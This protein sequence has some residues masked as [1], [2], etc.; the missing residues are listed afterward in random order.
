MIANRVRGLLI[1][2]AFFSLLALGWFASP[3]RAIDV[4]LDEKP[5]TLKTQPIVVSDQVMVPIIEVK[6]PW[7]ARSIWDADKSSLIVAVNNNAS[8]EV[9]VGSRP[10]K[11]SKIVKLYASKRIFGFLRSA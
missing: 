11:K 7:Y 10:L 3:A 8:I 2:V 5:L 4:Y 1:A 6:Q 9:T